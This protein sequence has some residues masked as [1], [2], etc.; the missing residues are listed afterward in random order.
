MT[1]PPFSAQDYS[2][3]S[4]VEQ[5]AIELF[6]SMG[7]ETANLYSEWSGSHSSEGRQTQQEVV[8]NSRL[9]SAMRRLN[10]ELP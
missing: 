9:M 2:E 1:P 6:A 3:D 10:P 8:L 7:W 5:P 4:L